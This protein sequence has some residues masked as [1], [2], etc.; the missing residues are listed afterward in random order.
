MHSP[1]CRRLAVLGFPDP[2]L[3]AD[4]VPA[5][6]RHG[7]IGLEGIDAMLLDFMRRKNLADDDIEAPAPG[8]RIPA[9]RVRR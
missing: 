8:W 6:I 1:H 3:A 5:I 7:P 9:R 2:F 4:A